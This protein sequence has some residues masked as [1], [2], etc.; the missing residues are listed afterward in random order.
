MKESPQTWQPF[1]DGAFAID[2]SVNDVLV[3][4]LVGP[5]N[6]TI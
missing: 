3:V 2:A 5:C 1:A 6:R 4:S